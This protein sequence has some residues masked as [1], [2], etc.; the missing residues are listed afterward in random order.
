MSIINHRKVKE[1]KILSEQMKQ[2]KENKME[3]SRFYKQYVSFPSIEDTDE[4]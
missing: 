2:N 3:Q 1:Q 4:K